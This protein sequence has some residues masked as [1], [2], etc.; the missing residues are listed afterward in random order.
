MRM[1][2]RTAPRL[3]LKPGAHAHQHVSA[4]VA[5][6]LLHNPC[7]PSPFSIVCWS[8]GVLGTCLHLDGAALANA[9][10][11]TLLWCS[12]ANSQPLHATVSWWSLP[13]HSE[14][15]G[16]GDTMT[17]QSQTASKHQE[18]LISAPGASAAYS[19]ACGRRSC[20]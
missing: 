12:K 18:G 19:S 11:G 20:G 15:S 1:R 14:I 9:K 16:L 3:Q 13:S 4:S 17:E 7:S 10:H 5:P 6:C 2:L 8:P